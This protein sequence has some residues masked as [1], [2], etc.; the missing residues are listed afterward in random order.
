M[1]PSFKL[2]DV[3]EIIGP[4]LAIGEAHLGERMKITHAYTELENPDRNWYAA[5]GMPTYPASSLRLVDPELKI[6]D[7]AKVISKECS[8]YG[9]I[10][11]ISGCVNNKYLSDGSNKHYSPACLRK[12]SPEEV[13]MHTGSISYKIEECYDNRVPSVAERIDAIDDRLDSLGSFLSD[14]LSDVGEL[15][16][17]IDTI[18]KKKALEVKRLYLLRHIAADM[19]M[20]CTEHISVQECRELYWL[21]ELEKV[22]KQL[23]EGQ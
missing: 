21:N 13:A 9:K 17:R 11:K 19:K 8:E 15:D 23:A 1:N 12:L 7:W 18:E 2:G 10:F 3:V 4:A 22:E 14:I 16:K 6:C 5:L 20:I